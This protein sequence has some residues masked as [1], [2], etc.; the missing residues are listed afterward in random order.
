MDNK[1]EM[2]LQE[3]IKSF[4]VLLKYFKQIGVLHHLDQYMIQESRNGEYY[5]VRYK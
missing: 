2:L 1:R 5:L 4:K 3:Y